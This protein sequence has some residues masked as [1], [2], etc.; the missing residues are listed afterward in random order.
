MKIDQFLALVKVNCYGRYMD[1]KK[2]KEI[3]ELRYEVLRK[4]KEVMPT[5]WLFIG[6]LWGLLLNLLA[7]IVHEMLKSLN[8]NLYILGVFGL[9]IVTILVFLW[10]LNKYYFGPIEKDREE[11]RKLEGM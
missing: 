8:Y 11:I 5:V 10:F 1:E 9:T 2:K 4:R 6:L 7:N 3:L